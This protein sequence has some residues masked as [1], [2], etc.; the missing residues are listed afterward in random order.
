MKGLF[1]TGTDTGVGKTVAS[2]ALVRALR[3]CNHDIG[4]MKPIETGVGTTGPSDAQALR[5]AGGALDPLGDICP[6]RFAL[7]A[8]PN[9]AAAAEGRTIDLRVV[10]RHFDALASRHHTMLVEGAGG[11]LVPTT[12]EATMADLARELELALVI[13]ARGALGT[14]H[15]TR[16]TLEAARSRGIEVAGVVIS[17]STG[18]LSHADTANLDFLRRELGGVLLGEIPPL[19]S[20]SPERDGRA[21]SELEIQRL[22]RFLAGASD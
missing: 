2:C 13:V 18:P 1:V 21:E 10:R 12:D 9:V 3:S 5:R 20:P 16:S 6:L 22:L 17:H 15:H 14:I 8:A 4:V 11:L 7:P 19:D